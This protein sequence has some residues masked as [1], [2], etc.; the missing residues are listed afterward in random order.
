MPQQ[1]I[2]PM[3]PAVLEAFRRWGYLEADLDPLGFSRPRPHPE[4]AV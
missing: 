3:D 2:E 4:L 1:D